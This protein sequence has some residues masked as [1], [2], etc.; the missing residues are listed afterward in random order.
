MSVQKNYISAIGLYR[1]LDYREQL[2]EL[3]DVTRESTSFAEML[4]LMNRTVPTAQTRYSYFYNGEHYENDT[5]VSWSDSTGGS[6]QGAG[7][8]TITT[9]SG[10]SYPLAG[11]LGMTKDQKVFYIV[12]KT[13]DA[14]GD[15][16][17]IKAVSPDVTSADF[18][19]TAGESVA[20]FSNA[21][22][23]GS[24]KPAYKRTTISQRTNQVQI[25]KNA[26]AI[27]DIQKAAKIEIDFQGQ[28]YYT[29]KMEY[30]VMM[31]HQGDISQAFLLGQVSDENFANTASTLDDANSNRVQTT[32]GLDQ[33]VTDYGINPASSTFDQPN[34]E[35][36]VETMA[37]ARCPQEYLLLGGQRGA[38]AFT[39]FAAALNNSVEFSPN[40]RLMIGGKTVDVDVETWK[41]YGFTFNFK[42]MSLLDHKNTINFSG[43]AGYQNN[44]YFMPLDKV[45]DEGSGKS[46]DRFRV[47]VLEG[48]GK[49]WWMDKTLTGKEAPVRTSHEAKLICELQTIAGLEVAGAEHFVKF[50]LP[51]WWCLILEPRLVRGSFH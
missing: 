21:Q 22:G 10:N 30:D 42:K 38:N 5:I 44:I 19:F 6:G 2:R 45:K 51:S 24:D 3:L 27:T 25:F 26:D 50:V 41:G 20:F 23:E 11:M 16:L 1:D 7:T 35:A 46:V 32:R 12:S 4:E 49:N 17:T 40:A 31:V 29:Y 8:L 47:R 18:G 14:A 43:S 9:A 13:A 36:L 37:V 28:P 34:I 39:N 33:Y 48:D 15:Q